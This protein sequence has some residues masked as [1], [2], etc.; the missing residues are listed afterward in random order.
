MKISKAKKDKITEQILI[1][2]YQVFPKY[3]FTA[4][5]AKEIARD[6]EFIKRLLIELKE[7]N[8]VIDIKKNQ[9]GHLFSR[10]IKWKLTNKV[11]ELFHL[12][13]KKV[14]P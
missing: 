5:I 3:P 14:S 13:N 11:Y 10:R 4:E 6:E 7:K 2:L 12:K 1:Y 9:K 8:V